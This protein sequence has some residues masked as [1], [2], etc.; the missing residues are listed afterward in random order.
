VIPEEGQQPTRRPERLFKLVYPHATVALR[1]R[2]DDS[3]ALM[4][5]T[6]SS[7]E[8]LDAPPPVQVATPVSHS[9]DFT[10]L[11]YIRAGSG[12]HW[13]G[14]DRHSI[15]AGDCFVIL[16]GQEHTYVSTGG[17]VMTN[18]LFYPELLEPY[19]DTLRATPGFKRFFSTEPLFREE[20]AFR[21]KLHLSLSNQKSLVALLDQLERDLAEKKPA[22]TVN[23]TGLF[24]QMIVLLSRCFDRRFESTNVRSEF[25]G[26]EQMVSAAIAYLEENCAND[27]RVEDIARS[28][29]ISPS[30]L[31]HVF[32]E[33]TGMSLLDYLTRMRV[34][35]ACQMLAESDQSVTAIAYALG[36][37]DSAYFTRLFGK[38]IGL[39]PTAYRKQV[40]LSKQT[41]E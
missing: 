19:R 35:R 3:F 1:K 16:P 36:F 31:S 6:R 22:Y 24:L 34:E 4:V 20:A 38:A 32:K 12:L 26:K 28:V 40:E 15:Y 11:V 21:Y 41:A 10:E 25:E 23:C 8:A 30:R 29:F 39:S 5:D 18:V 13:H 2:G 33:T 27:V 37:H 9:H 17:L 7:A 14:S